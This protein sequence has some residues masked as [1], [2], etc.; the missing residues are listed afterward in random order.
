MSGYVVGH[1]SFKDNLNDF[2]LTI[3]NVTKIDI[4]AYRCECFRP[5]HYYSPIALLNDVVPPLPTPFVEEPQNSESGN[6]RK[7]DLQM[8]TT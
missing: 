3:H 8:C 6:W 5:R 7:G 1:Y 4:G 2:S